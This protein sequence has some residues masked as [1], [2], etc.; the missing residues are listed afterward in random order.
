MYD[1]CI[2]VD[3]KV[4]ICFVTVKISKLSLPL[5]FRHGHG[6]TS[7]LLFRTAGYK[8]KRKATERETEWLLAGHISAVDLH[9]IR[10]YSGRAAFEPCGLLHA[11]FA[12]RTKVF[13]GLC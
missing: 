13:E 5:F 4:F 2:T 12:L 11:A 10:C 7:E 1:L 8:R 9:I 6:V 3:G